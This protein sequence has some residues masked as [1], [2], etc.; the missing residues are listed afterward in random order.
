MKN[1]DLLKLKIKIKTKNNIAYQEMAILLD[2]PDFLQMLPDLR[3]I[4]KVKELLSLN[5]YFVGT[6]YFRPETEFEVKIY[7]KKYKRIKEFKERFPEQFEFIRSGQVTDPTGALILECNLLCFEFNRPLFFAEI[8]CQAIFC[9]TVDNTFYKATEAKVLDIGEM[10]GSE[11]TL[12]QA[13]ILISPTS[14]YKDIKAAFRKARKFIETDERL[15]YYQPRVDTVS[16]I[17]K[18]RH[19]YWERLKEKKYKEIADDWCDKHEK[20]TITYLDVIKGVKTYKKL[21]A[22]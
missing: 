12:P 18:Y 17:R 10:G 5:K 3:K 1:E 15:S 16:N 7:L 2:K 4:Y 22:R 20:E 9:G 13:A 11:L 19:W 21:L 8:I 6:D 14:R